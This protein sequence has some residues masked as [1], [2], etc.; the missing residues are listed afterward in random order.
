MRG[1]PKR[2]MQLFVVRHARAFDQTAELWP[3]DSLRPLTKGGERAFRKLATSI[4]K[5]FD[6]PSVVLASSYERA[7]KTAKILTKRAGWPKALRCEAL[8]CHAGSDV[9]Q[10][11]SQVATM[12]APSLA[13]VGHEPLLSEVVSDLIGAGGGSI[14][15]SKGAVAVLE[16]ELNGPAGSTG[17]QSIRMGTAT[18]LALVE[19]RLISVD[20]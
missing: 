4:G 11:L 19:P 20:D 12:H 16:V 13:I 8:E 5:R 1:Y 3:D 6:P 9:P 15:M 10:V 2:P 17:V 18:L 7:W 14:V